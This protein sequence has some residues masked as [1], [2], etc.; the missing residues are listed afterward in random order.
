M[1]VLKLYDCSLNCFSPKH[2]KESLGPKENDIMFDLKTYSKN[3]NIKFVNNYKDSDRIIT[4][5]TY[6]KQIVN[7]SNKNNIVDENMYK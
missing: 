3:L 5:T 4:N 2:R 1:S 7:Y 6:T